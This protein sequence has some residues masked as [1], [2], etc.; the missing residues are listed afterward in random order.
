[1]I[2]GCIYIANRCTPVPQVQYAIPD[3]YL[4]IQ[5]SVIQYTCVDGYVPVPSMPH[6]LPTFCN[7][8]N[9]EPAELTGCEGATISVLKLVTNVRNIDIVVCDVTQYWSL[10]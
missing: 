3:S 5:G 6:L 4:A 8:I 10:S 2:Y 9:W 1:M 7:G